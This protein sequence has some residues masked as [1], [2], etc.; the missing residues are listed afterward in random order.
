[1]QNVS[2]S[3]TPSIQGS[4]TEQYA[5]GARCR[6]MDGEVM[7]KIC[8]EVQQY[9]LVKFGNLVAVCLPEHLKVCPLLSPVT[10]FLFCH[11]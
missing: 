3:G 8:A 6:D 9:L 10:V 11:K 2:V 5:L 1:M 7:Q 4:V